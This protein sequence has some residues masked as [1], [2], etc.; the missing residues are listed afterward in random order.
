MG[1]NSLLECT[2]FGTIVGKKLPIKNTRVNLTT[3]GIP[4][5]KPAKEVRNVTIEEL[6]THNN[7]EDCWVAINGVIYDF[8]EFAEE[9]PAG[10][11]SIH[12]LAGK[13][14]SEAFGAV[15]NERILEDFD[16][17]I[18]GRL[19]NSPD[20]F[21]KANDQ[22][23]RKITH[24]ELNVHNSPQ[25]CWIA[26]HGDVYNITEFARDH[27]GGPSLIYELAGQDGTES[28]DVVHSMTKLSL[29][30]SAKI[31]KLID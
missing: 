15:H 8:T 31:G 6:E 18:I 13:D 23:S 25:D 26:L 27:P 4:E 30:E 14:G 2:V 11:E 28:F 1:G 17:E 7:E 3:V 20:T 5:T 21:Q 22:L 12:I 10:A 9:H 24:G 19:V 16:N 29:I